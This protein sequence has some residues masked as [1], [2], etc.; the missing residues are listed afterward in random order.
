MESAVSLRNL[1]K[2]FP[3]R[4]NKREK[5]VA[6]DDVTLEVKRG[7]ILAMAGPRGS[8]KSTIL[9]MIA[10][11]EKPSSGEIY[12]DGERIDN[13]PARARNIGYMVQGNP[14]FSHGNVF[15]NISFGLRLRKMPKRERR[16]RVEEI[17]FL[18]DLE[19]LENCKPHQLSE[20][21]QQRVAL[22]SALAPEPRVLLLDEPFSW[23][24]TE[25]RQ[26]LKADTKRWQRELK[27]PT[28]LVTNDQSDA[29]E[30]GDRVAILNAGRFE[31]VDTSHNI[32]NYPA[33]P[34]VASF[35]G[36][37]NG[38]AN[39]Q[40]GGRADVAGGLQP[41]DDGDPQI[42]STTRSFLGYPVLLD[43]DLKILKASRVLFPGRN[44]SN[45]ELN[46]GGHGVIP[47]GSLKIFP[48]GPVELSRT[49]TANPDSAISANGQSES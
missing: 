14:R 42:A 48:S 9:K 40:E 44:T 23:L 32:S 16:Q 28:I 13:L 2:V 35:L 41:L 18:I 10:G 8:G 5:H 15:D 6:V 47:F 19:G 26:G 11:L 30:L 12:V 7:E 4:R 38:Y 25:S 1:S 3:G 49:K 33:S 31:Q 43:L 21:E 24:G 34:F 37:V 22:A 17:M 45:H 20:S 27:I 29:L 39:G 46:P 36:I